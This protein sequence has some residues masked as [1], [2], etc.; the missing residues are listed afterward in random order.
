MAIISTGY[1]LSVWPMIRKHCDVQSFKKYHN[2]LKNKIKIREQK[3]CCSVRQPMFMNKIS[4]TFLLILVMNKERKELQKRGFFFYICHTAA[5]PVAIQ[6]AFPRKTLML[7]FF[8]VTR[9][10]HVYNNIYIYIYI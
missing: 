2:K 10:Y 4:T 1:D 7:I 6:K 3:L 9:E 5:I 8:F